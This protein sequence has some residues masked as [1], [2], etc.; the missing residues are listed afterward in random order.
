MQPYH[1]QMTETGGLDRQALLLT[2][3]C[4]PNQDHSIHE[5]MFS[6]PHTALAVAPLSFQNLIAEVTTLTPMTLL[7]IV[8][9]DGRKPFNVLT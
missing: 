3:V 4:L 5:Y 9:C 8:K 1:E 2:Y 6:A 7:Y